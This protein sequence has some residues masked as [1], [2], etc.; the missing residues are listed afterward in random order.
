MC[1]L[2]LSVFFF[3]N[4]FLNFYV[5][6]SITSFFLTVFGLGIWDTI[7]FLHSSLTLVSSD[8]L[9]HFLPS[10][11]QCLRFISPVD[12]TFIYWMRGIRLH[13]SPFDG[14][15]SLTFPLLFCHTISTIYHISYKHWLCF[16]TFYLNLSVNFESVVYWPHTFLMAFYKSYIYWN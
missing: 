3:F 6:K 4:E 2:I 11:L 7:S 12:F 5:M 9:L 14:L 8:I 15:I 10:A 1:L 13:F 16:W